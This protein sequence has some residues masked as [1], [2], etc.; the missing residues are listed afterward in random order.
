MGRINAG[1]R[2]A[3]AV[4]AVT[5]ALSIG[6]SVYH[7]VTHQAPLLPTILGQWSLLA[8]SVAFGGGGYYALSSVE[9][10]AERAIIGW[11]ASIAYLLGG[12]VSGGY[13]YHEHLTPEVKFGLDSVVFQATFVAVAAGIAGLV[14][15]RQ[16]VSRTRARE[17]LEA[18]FVELER[19]NERLEEFASIVSHDLRNPLNVAEGRLELAREEYDSED[20]DA[21]TRAHTRM[22]TLIEDLLTQA[23]EGETVDET[24]LTDLVNLTENCWRN[25]ATADA[26]LMT[27]IDRRIHADES[28]LQQLLENLFRNAVEHVCEDVTITVGEMEGGFYVED[29]GPGIPENQRD[30]VFDAGYSTTDEGTGF[31]LSIVK[32]VAQAHGWDVHVSAG[33]SEGARFEITG[34]AYSDQ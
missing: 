3:V 11:R 2:S 18:T 22:N 10:G 29:D 31:G 27:D 7:L 25:V 9:T 28:R 5:V 33:S 13:A 15:G 16:I 4:F 20:L 34:V 26:T 30:E 8:L 1:P 21:V 23:R 32:Q 14:I 12:L 24:Q 17:D 19:A 6:V